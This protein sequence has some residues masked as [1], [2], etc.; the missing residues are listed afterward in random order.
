M[1]LISHR[2][3][4]NGKTPELENSVSYITDALRQDYQVEIDVWKINKELLLGHDSPLHYTA[5]LFLDNPKFWLHAKNIEALEFLLKNTKYANVF[6]HQEDNFTLTNKGFIWTYPNKT[7]T[8]SSI[9][10]LPELGYF[11]D[12]SSCQGI[13]SDFI[14]NYKS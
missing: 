1:I 11:G 14:A 6:W 8:Q 9:C 5:L 3:N 2:G 4:T 10:V 7:L 12:L 13:C